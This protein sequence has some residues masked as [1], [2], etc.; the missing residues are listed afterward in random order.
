MYHDSPTLW[1]N[2]LWQGLRDDGWPWD[3]TTQ[4]TCPNQD[5]K[6]SLRAKVIAQSEGVW[7]AQGLAQA[8]EQIAEECGEKLRVRSR[9]ENGSW[10]KRGTE[11]VH[12]V[13]SARMVLALERPFLNLAAYA[14]GIATTTHEL[15][16]IVRGAC[17][18]RTPRVT[19][20]R[21]TLPGYR[22][23]AIHALQV[24]GGYSHRVSLA[25]GVL[26]KEN[27]IAAAGGVRKAVTRA[28]A[29]A[30]HLLAIEIEV[31]NA[32]ELDE[33]IEAGADVVMLDNFSPAQVRAALVRIN[34]AERLPCVEVSGGIHI[35]NIAQYS[36]PGVDVIS[37]GSLTHSV[38][39]LDLSLL[40]DGATGQR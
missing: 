18:K 3:W 10:L 33:A 15:T 34:Q 13:G 35:G 19:A 27:H 5:K 16:Q 36:L 29:L 25:G 20:T 24:G 26:I 11:V 9:V 12:W 39:S 40:V 7:A 30:P 4:A 2:L 28:R 31:R 22:D 17:P 32:R 23:L 1:K 6:G 8:C 21:K 37:I 14:S 38:R